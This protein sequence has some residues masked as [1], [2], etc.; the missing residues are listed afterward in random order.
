MPTDFAKLARITLINISL[1]AAALLPA[2][3]VKLSVF[4][5]NEAVSNMIFIGCA[6]LTLLTW[7]C[8]LTIT[9]H[10]L[11]REVRPLLEKRFKRT[12]MPA[13]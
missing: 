7:L 3:I 10:L 2:F 5:P 9:K 6:L 8:M 12:P 11:Y 4:R 1:A 13:V